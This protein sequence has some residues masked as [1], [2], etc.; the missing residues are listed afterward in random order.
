MNRI[1][2]GKRKR[3]IELLTEREFQ[4]IPMSKIKT[5]DYGIDSN[6]NMD[7]MDSV[8][9]EHGLLSPLSVVKE[10]EKYIIID[11]VRRFK[12]FERF[13][14]G[15]IPCYI[16]GKNLSKEDRTI[17]ALGANK[18]HRE[19]DNELNIRYTKLLISECSQGMIKEH[20]ISSSL[21]K[22]TGISD[23]Q[24]RKYKSIVNLGTEAVIDSV[25]E[26]RL[27]INEACAIAT[28][29]P[30]EKQDGYVK[31]ISQLSKPTA[32]SFVDRISKN[33]L[34]KSET[35]VVDK[36]IKDIDNLSTSEVNKV[37][38]IQ[39]D[40]FNFAKT[41]KKMKNDFI[42]FLKYVSE[43]KPGD[44]EDIDDVVDLCKKIALKY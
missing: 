39:F 2:E 23:R 32:K 20:N 18:V 30:E 31:I 13:F 21:S 4:M 17:L 5:E 36:V 35:K 29:V 38:S 16:V 42:K 6:Y 27:T 24:A 9:E 11:G 12:S 15:K 14:D 43:C 3:A 10:G 33:D 37:I 8:I 19:T 41:Y 28:N 25:S 1:K 44:I 26:N 22:L 7:M 34:T 40:D